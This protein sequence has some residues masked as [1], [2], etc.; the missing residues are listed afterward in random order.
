M[1]E[2][3]FLPIMRDEMYKDIKVEAIGL[4]RKRQ[5]LQLALVGDARIV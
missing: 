1:T 5:E 4:K 2:Q 3:C